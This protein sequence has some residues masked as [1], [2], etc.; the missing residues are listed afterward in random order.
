MSSELATFRVPAGTV[1]RLR[2]IAH[3]RSLASG[4]DVSWCGILR[5]LVEKALDDEANTTPRPGHTPV[6]PHQQ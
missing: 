4:Q 6:T 3:R 2:T 1:K 5:Q